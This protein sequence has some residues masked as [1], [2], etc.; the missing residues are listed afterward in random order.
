MEKKKIKILC[1]G[2]SNTWGYVPLSG[3]RYSS[4]VRWTGVLQEE[5]GQGYLVVEDGV[6]GRSTDVDDPRP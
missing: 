4:D 5:L 1:F 3:E 6:N 2:D